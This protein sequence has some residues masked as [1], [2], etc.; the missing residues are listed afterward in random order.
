MVFLQGGFLAL[1]YLVP[2]LVNVIIDVGRKLDMLLL[3]FG[4]TDSGN[5]QYV[6]YFEARRGYL[7]QDVFR[8]DLYACLEYMVS[9]PQIKYQLE[10][11]R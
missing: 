3:K 8:G 5:M 7:R 1:S 11:V 2:L 4:V 10:A 9:N 6:V